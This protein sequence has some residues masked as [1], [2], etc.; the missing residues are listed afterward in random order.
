MNLVGSDSEQHTYLP[1]PRIII[2]ARPLGKV[3]G[4]P[5]SSIKAAA[6]APLKQKKISGRHTTYNYLTWYLNIRLHP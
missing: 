4:I 5:P 2:E 6:A 3:P 1:V